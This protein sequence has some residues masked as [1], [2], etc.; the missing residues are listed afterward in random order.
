MFRSVLSVLVVSCSLLGCGSEQKSSIFGNSE[1]RHLLLSCQADGVYRAVVRLV[2]DDWKYFP[3]YDRR[4]EDTFALVYKF[5]Q[6]LDRY[7]LKRG[8]RQCCLITNH[9]LVHKGQTRCF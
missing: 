6:N 1:A 8:L 2:Q 4:H 9:N 3:G 5:P 7:G